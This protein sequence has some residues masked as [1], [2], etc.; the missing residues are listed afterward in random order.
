MAIFE[1]VNQLNRGAT[2]ITARGEREQ[3]AELNLLAGKRARAST[4]Y[5]SA[6]N[7]LVAGAA[8]LPQDSWERRH[9][10]T[11]E[12]ELLRAEC[13]F[14]T[15][16]LAEAEERLAALSTR[17]ATTVQRA[18]VACLRV[19]LYMTIDQSDRAVAVGLDY[20]RHLGI[21][22][23]PQPTKAEASREY[24]R[25]W[26]QLGSR[27]IEELSELPL[28][29]DPE[30]LATVDLLIRIAVPAFFRSSYLFSLA[31]CR[32]V[33]LSLKHGNRDAACSAYELF[34]MFAGPLFGNYDAGFRFGRLGCELVE[35]RPELKRFQ[36]RT[37]ENFGFVVAWT[38]HVRIGGD[39]LRRAFEIANRVGDLTYAGLARAQLNA[40]LLFAGDALVEA[41]REAES[42]LEFA[43]KLRFGVVVCWITGQLGLIR[44][45]R[46]LTAKFGSFDDGRFDEREFQSHLGSQSALALPECW[47]WIRKLQAHFLAGD[48]AAAVDASSKA[49]PLLSTSMSLLETA[50]Y[51]FY[52]ALSRAVSWDIGAAGDR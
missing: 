19:D 43:Q 29:S 6:L 30:S 36:A 49:Q 34:G 52:G 24:E 21:D 9:E 27:T 37:L 45:L 7:Y 33:N 22:W 40:N 13:E 15:G 18:T 3:L 47:Y 39:L 41:Q 44:S 28:M 11:F 12:L 2:L 5:A 48:Y 8:R 31:T 51:H 35:R 4:A 25:I 17:A 38:R 14:V 46:G 42:G 20:L 16:A 26:S 32:A 23:S 50:E 1:I 10:L